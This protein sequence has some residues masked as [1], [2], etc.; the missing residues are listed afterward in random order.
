MKR[1]NLIEMPG[2]IALLALGQPWITEAHM[3]DLMA[4]VDI[5][6]RISKDDTITALCLEGK[7][8][9]LDGSKDYD[10]IRKAI[11]PVIHWISQQPNRV[12]HDA[13]LQRLKE[14]DESKRVS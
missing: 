7:R 3:C 10:A 5:G 4:A 11:G 13:A 8:L 2:Q 6:E 12:I 9:L 14:Y 1:L